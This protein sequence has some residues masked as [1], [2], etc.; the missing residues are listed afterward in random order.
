MKTFFSHLVYPFL[1]TLENMSN[2]YVKFT[3]L[4]GLESLI[5]SK[6]NQDSGFTEN[7]LGC[8]HFVA[9]CLLNYHHSQRLFSKTV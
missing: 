8:A 2:L 3:K 7:S 6:K 1:M 9:E 4:P 5:L